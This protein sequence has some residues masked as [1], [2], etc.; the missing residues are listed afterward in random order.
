MAVAARLHFEEPPR[1]STPLQ[2]SDEEM[3]AV[4][5]AVAP[6]AFGERDRFLRELADELAQYPRGEIGVGLVHRLARQLQRGFVLQ[7]RKETE[8]G[9][10]VPKYSRTAQREARA[11]R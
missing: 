5:A 1:L 10:G 9:S 6:I 4:L 3:Q 2:L 8:T 7:A 11:G